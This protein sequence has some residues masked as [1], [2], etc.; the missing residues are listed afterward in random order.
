[1]CF[2]TRKY[3][4]DRTLEDPATF[5]SSTECA[6]HHAD[7]QKYGGQY[8]ARTREMAEPFSGLLGLGRIFPLGLPILHSDAEL[9]KHG[10]HSKQ[11]KQTQGCILQ[12][13]HLT[14]G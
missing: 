7:H 10:Q 5:L 6:E 2:F 11:C 1:M 12:R 3:K 9:E 8:R 14:A 13:A 4:N